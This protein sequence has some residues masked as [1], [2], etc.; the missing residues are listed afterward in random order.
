MKHLYP[1]LAIATLLICAQLQSSAAQQPKPASDKPLNYVL[2]LVDD[3]GWMDLGCQGSTFYETPHI[4]RLAAEGMRFT[5]GYA[6]CAVCSP[7]RAAVQTGRYP[8]RLFVTDWI[9]SRFQGGNIPKDGVN[10]CLR[11]TDQWAGKD[12]LCPP[13]ALWMES[14]EV[15]IAEALKP[16]G[17]QSCYIGKW[18]LGADPWYPTEQGYDEN[19]GGCDYGQPPNYFDPF[20][21]PKGRHEMLRAGIPSLPGRQSG[22]YLSDREADEAVSFIERNQEKPFFLMLANYAVHTPIQ[23]KADVTAKYQAKLTT[24][25]IGQKNAKYAAMVESVDDAVG[26]VRQTLR[27]LAIDD[28]TVI[29][30]TS[31]NGGLLGP[32]DNRP[33]RSGKGYAYEGGIRVP[34]IV[35]WPGVVA[36]GSTCDV[37]VTSVDV[38]PTIVS[39]AGQAVSADLDIDGLDLQ[40]LLRQTGKLD[41]SAIYWHFPHYR[42]PPGPYSIIRDGEWKLIKW[43]QGPKSLFNLADD[44]G[45]KTDLAETMPNKVASLEQKLM[46]H[47]ASVGAKVPLAKVATK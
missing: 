11:P 21:Q 31:D 39:S 18:H 6:A 23:A 16:A 42:H 33:L 44:L 9:R 45:E 29:I 38:F 1:A 10:P 12:V 14:S 32:T 20:N 41:R 5:N 7:T 4:D 34:F 13:N 3:L 30:F 46:K 43:Y 37:P 24:G 40:P 15:T 27:K 28:R 47:L 22:Q 17:Y 25:Q 19:H 26:R 2:V 8:A 36:A 35:K